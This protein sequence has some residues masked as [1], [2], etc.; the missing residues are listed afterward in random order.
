MSIR[1]LP[2]A[3]EDLYAGRLFYDKQGDGLG[4]YFF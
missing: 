1:I 2:S 3:I 4:E